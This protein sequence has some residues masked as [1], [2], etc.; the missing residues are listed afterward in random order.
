MFFEII[1]LTLGSVLILSSSVTII[2]NMR[3]KRV[4][5]PVSATVVDIHR[6]RRAGKNVSHTQYH[7]VF[8]YYVSGKPT[9]AQ[10][11]GT[12][13]VK[14]SVGTVME[15]LYDPYKPERILVD[16]AAAAGSTAPIWIGIAL[17]VGSVLS[18]SGIKLPKAGTPSGYIVL[19]VM[20]LFFALIIFIVV[21]SIRG[22]G[23]KLTQHALTEQTSDNVLIAAK[24]ENSTITFQF[25]NG[26]Q[27]DYIVP[28][29]AYSDLQEG[30]WGKLTFHGTIFVRFERTY[31]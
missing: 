26:N 6:T 5:V 18:M 4:G 29:S 31:R 2:R 7:P 3:L 28:E 27:I 30:D 21:R 9:K 22:V 10:G 13:E 17:V 23:K 14:Y 15:I 1:F 24:K 25:V 11:P 16:N 8:E 20:L 12:S 19:S